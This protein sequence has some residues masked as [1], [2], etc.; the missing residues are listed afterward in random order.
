[1]GMKLFRT[2][3]LAKGTPTASKLAVFLGSGKGCGWTGSMF[4]VQ[5]S[6]SRIQRGNLSANPKIRL[7]LLSMPFNLER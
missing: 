1:V 5:S 4:K 6:G 7:A 3:C 2:Y